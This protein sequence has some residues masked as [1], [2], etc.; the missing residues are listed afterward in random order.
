MVARQYAYLGGD[1]PE[2]PPGRAGAAENV[3]EVFFAAVFRPPT[4][5]E[6]ALLRR[7]L[8]SA[9]DFCGDAEGDVALILPRPG[10]ISPWASKAGDILRNCGLSFVSRLERGA[11]MRGGD[12]DAVADRMTQI[13]LRP[14]DLGGWRRLF[15]NPPPRREATVAATAESISKLNAARGWALSAEEIA[16][17][18]ALYARLG[19]AP[20]EAE[21]TMFAQANS[22]H[23]RHKIFRG[24][25][26]DGGDSMMDLIRRTHE[27]APEGVLTA[28]ADNA[29]VISAA[30]G[31]DFSPGEDGVYR[32]GEGGLL[33][34]AKAETHNHPTA[35]SPFPGAATGSGGE[36]RDEAAA[37]RGAASRAGFAGFIV[38]HLRIAGQNPPARHAPAPHLASP[39]EIMTDAPLGAANYCNEFGRPSLGGFFRS[40]E[41]F[42]GERRIGFHKPVMLAGGIGHMRPQSAGK[43]PIPPGAKIVQLG[44]PG[45]RIGVGGG[46]ASSRGGS[47]DDFASVQRDNAE[48][49]RRAQEVLDACRRAPGGG[50]LL[51]LH[52]VG[53]GGIANAV[54][55]MV[56]DS[57]V[58]ARIS[59]SAIPVEDKSLSP[60][61]IWCNESQERYVLALAAADVP[62]FAA[63]CE[64]EGC[65]FS[66]LGEAAD[67][68]RIALSDGAGFAVDLP[69]SD[70][71]GDIPRRPRRVSE[72]NGG[73]GAE[74][75]SAFPDADLSAACLEV[76]RHPT[77][78]CKRFLIAIG[79]R[80]VGGLTARDQ[81]VGPLQTPVSDCAAFFNG[82]EGTGGAAF[83]LGERPEIAMLNPAA[84]ARMAIA[85]AL[86]NLA[87]AG[88]G[89][90]WRVKLSLNWLANCGED[91]DGGG[92]R[93]A[94]RAASD[95]C[96]ALRTGVVVGKDSLSM[97]ARAE[98][99]ESVESPPFPVA[100]AF[101]PHDDVRR[102]L[103]PQLRGGDS[104]LMLAEPSGLRR[105][106]GGVFADIFSAR[107]A[108]PDI[109][110]AEMAAFWR[111]VSECHCRGLLRAYHDRS[112]GGLWACACEMAFAA[113]LGITLIL[114]PLFPAARTDGGEIGGDIFAAAGRRRTLAALFNEEIG[115]LLEVAAADAEAVL[116]IFADAGMAGCL[117]TAGRI[118]RERRMKIHRGGRKLFDRDLDELRREW[119]AVSYAVCRRRDDPEC[120]KEEHERDSDEARLF[121]RLPD[122]FPKDFRAAAPH[123][124][125][126]R[127]RVAIL[128]ERGSNGQR[129]MAAAFTRAGFDATDITTSDLRDGRRRL[130]EFAGIALCGGFS[131]GDVLGAGRGWAEGV[132]Q[133]PMLADMF[134]AFFADKNTFAFGACNGCQA[135]SLLQPLTADAESWR[136]PRFAANRSGRF[137]A[138]FVMAEILP[139]PS[140]L[141]AGMDGAML[142]LASS[143]AEGRA[144]WKEEN[145]TAAA[146]VLRFVDGRGKPATRYPQNPAGGDGRCGFCSPD[147]RITITMPHPERVFRGG[148]MSWRPPEWEGD[149]SPWLQ[150]FINARRFVN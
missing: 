147:G 50:M 84:G 112:D 74:N 146:A 127:P 97:R 59:L 103:T 149:A 141:F 41:A 10:V 88:I 55:E 129:E 3:R 148:Q 75:D 51:S 117:Q 61:E 134:A 47:G 62:A 12:A 122:Q 48:M 108:P 77:T 57:R 26:E 121:A 66:V 144:V 54:A 29:A 138:R 13:V 101:A 7:L 52:D 78:A 43:K 68:G 39:L 23:C 2:M 30:A 110:A 42:C 116:Q 126:V 96:V 36:I 100:T 19:R 28:F 93:A 71:L 89:E 136:F 72:E 15:K 56:Y 35:I 53:A 33:L 32:R 60:S 145:A 142:P 18:C 106:G 65:P 104:F 83:A 139:S 70:I 40:L 123:I 27:A 76:L 135:L 37:G 115:A 128:R 14:P 21:L 49:Q 44:G 16:H 132:L 8:N 133:T 124:G 86:A 99:G 130:G 143:N 150:M 34:V 73:G 105:L 24:G 131:F 22:E 92:L 113:D 31:E 118:N 120:A 102:I 63:I 79:D 9:G 25:W 1:A 58:G 5:A 111:A 20:E 46:A 6:D 109:A 98:S 80:T 107:D 17:L 69:L 38:S 81:M 140:P 125:G 4:A 82:Y 64:R 85:E 91:G 119:D 95:F 90:L 94:V 137:E 67:G 87:G 45:F 11:L 114:D